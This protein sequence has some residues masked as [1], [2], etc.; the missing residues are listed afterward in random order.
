VRDSAEAYI[1]KQDPPQF[2]DD[3]QINHIRIGQGIA[4]WLNIGKPA[5]KGD[6][7]SPASGVN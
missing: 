7:T 6:S 2:G 1:Y 4:I 5:P 3:G